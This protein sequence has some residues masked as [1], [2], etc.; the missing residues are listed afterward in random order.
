MNLV[1]LFNFVDL[2]ILVILV[3]LDFPVIWLN[4]VDLVSSH[5]WDFCIFWMV[6]EPGI[7][8]V[9]LLGF[10]LLTGTHMN[11]KLRDVKSKHLYKI[12]YRPSGLVA[13]KLIHFTFARIHKNFLLVNK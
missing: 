1:V 9:R 11:T 2:V 3:I 7:R 10:L 4:L 5:F 6:V 13:L 8:M 12:L